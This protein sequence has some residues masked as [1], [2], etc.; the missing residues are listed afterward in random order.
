MIPED[1]ECNQQKRRLKTEQCLNM[2]IRKA[3]K[4]EDA[5]GKLR[6]GEDDKFLD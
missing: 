2:H 3:H 4:A 6:E 1:F 5:L